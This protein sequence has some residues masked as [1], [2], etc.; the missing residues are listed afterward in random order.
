[1]NIHKFVVYITVNVIT[2]DRYIG[3]TSVG[4][5]K[6][7]TIHLTKSKNN[8]R[9]CPKFYSA[10]RKYGK[11]AF[12]WN[13]VAT[14]DSAAEAFA[15]EIRLIAELKPEYNLTAGGE[16]TVGCISRNRKSVTCLEDGK[17]FFSASE[18]AKFYDMSNITISDI[19]RGKYRSAKGRHFIF[20]EIMYSGKER[21]EIVKKIEAMHAQRRRQV[22]EINRP[23]RGVING[24]DAA[25]RSAAGPQKL[26]KKVV[27]IEDGRIFKSVNTTARHYNVNASAISQLCSGA[28]LNVNGV[29]TKRLSV[30]GLHFEY[31]KEDA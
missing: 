21:E 15:E 9:G 8:E 27:C 23:Y 13:V 31:I 2:N 12:S 24:M 29:T 26:S 1:M 18:A 20:G 4:L 25:G 28:M 14:F 30:G 10:I 6:R 11:D 22:S 3:F 5:S 19:C 16:G 17:S 7:K